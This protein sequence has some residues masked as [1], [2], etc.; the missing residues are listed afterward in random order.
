MLSAC[1]MPTLLAK[2]WISWPWN[3]EMFI[4]N[5][6]NEACGGKLAVFRWKGKDLERKLYHK[7]VNF[8]LK[9]KSY[10]ML[11]NMLQLSADHHPSLCS[12]VYAGGFF[13]WSLLY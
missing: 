1:Q 2:Q 11:E 7:I 12:C 13:I 10:S 3:L 6:L 5:Q 4:D 9:V 8:L